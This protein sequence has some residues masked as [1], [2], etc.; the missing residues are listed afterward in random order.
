MN[1]GA[2]NLPLLLKFIIILN[3]IIKKNDG[4]VS[5]VGRKSS[6]PGTS[7]THNTSLATAAQLLPTIR[8]KPKTEVEQQADP[9]EDRDL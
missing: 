2:N 8:R 7:A 1:V 9:Q 4:Q 3:S 5:T 6:S